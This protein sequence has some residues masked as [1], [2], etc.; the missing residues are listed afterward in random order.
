MMVSV[1][2]VLLVVPSTTY[3][4]A[5]FLQ[6]AATLG[7]DVAVAT[8]AALAFKDPLGDQTRSVKVCLED[9]EGAGK[10]IA[11]FARRFPVDA[12]LAVDDR[13]G[14]VANAA[15]SLLGLPHN[16][17][18]ALVASRDKV[19]MRIACARAGV[20]QPGFEV[21]RP[22]DDVSTIAGALGLPCVVKPAMLSASRGVIRVDRA[23]DV[24]R[25]VERVRKILS[26]AGEDP[27]GPVLIERFVPG[28]EIAIDGI[29]DQGSFVTVAIFDKPDP[30]D[31]P[32]FEETIY[33]TPSRLE[34]CVQKRAIEVAHLAA[35]ALG[36]SHGPVH[37]ELRISAGKPYFIELAARSIGG[38]CSRSVAQGGAWTLE[39]LILANAI[40]RGVPRPGKGAIQLASD[41]SG[42]MMI[43]IEH[44]GV[45]ESADGIAAARAVPGVTGV[46]ITVHR[47]QPVVA[48]PEGDR[49]LGFIFAR[50]STPEG[51]ERA[52]REAHAALGVRITDLHSSNVE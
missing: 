11:E 1:P 3:R 38:L 41:A 35:I 52:L 19:A 44:S 34:L 42:V 29:L 25:T 50:G 43:P 4:A 8:D 51:V 31:G 36:L 21:V 47:G 28:A 22:G 49:Y 9:L 16:P 2:R 33:V 6:A 7:I 24:P 5:D 23:E 45:F 26:S 37:A 10:A 18:E 14:A 17:L 48:L 46:T 39:E 27:S 20:G 12:V 32:Y 30:L 40:G 13:A 15:A